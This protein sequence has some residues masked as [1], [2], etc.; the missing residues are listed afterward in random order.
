MQ[1][2]R[3]FIGSTAAVAAAAGATVFQTSLGHAQ[4]PSGAAKTIDP[5]VDA[6]VK[7]IQQA[8][9]DLTRGKGE[10]GRRIAQ[11]LRVWA[12]YGE[13]RSYNTQFTQA[14]QR[15]VASRG[16][17]EIVYGAVNHAEL[18][19]YAE[20]LGVT[21]TIDLHQASDPA[22]RDKALDRLLKEGITPSLRAAAETLERGA[23]WLDEHR[24]SVQPVAF[25]RDCGCNDICIGAVL[26]KEQMDVVCAISVLFPP[27]A[28][29][30]V[31]MIMCWLT[32]ASMCGICK[33]ALCW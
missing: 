14:A 11:T 29:F 26:M 9:A 30:C 4:A 28:D 17:Q 24:P 23:K 12:A 3:A 13:S 8:T 21:G 10:G 15:A 32:L 20:R 16:R 27:I 19:R 31:A 33:I 18:E 6:F 5:V 1:N 7:E 25:A 22:A 2:R